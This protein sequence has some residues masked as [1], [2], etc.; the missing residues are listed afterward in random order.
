MSAARI[1][2]CEA[3]PM[4]QRIA[5]TRFDLPQPFGPTTP[6]RPFSIW[7]SVGSTNDL[8]PISRRRVSFMSRRSPSAG[9]AARGLLP[10]SAYGDSSSRTAASRGR[11]N[12]RRRQGNIG[13][14]LLRKFS[15]PLH[16]SNAQTGAP[17]ALRQG[18]KPLSALKIAVDLLADVGRRR[19]ARVLLAVDEKSGRARYAELLG[20]PFAHPFDAVLDLVIRQAGLEALL[21]EAGLLGDRHQGLERLLHHPFPLLL[22]QGVDDR[23]VF[24]VAGAAR[25]H[26]ARH[27][28]RAERELAED[29]VHLS[30]VDVFRFDLGILMDE[31]VRA[32]GAGHRRVFDQGDRRLRVALGLLAER[33]RAHQLLFRSLRERR[34]HEPEAVR[35]TAEN[36]AGERQG[37]RS[38]T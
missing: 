3:S 20:G 30:G 5:S 15:L 36:R 23:E 1:A 32:V 29:E 22:E 6:V 19:V 25:Q 14:A 13:C 26:V 8:K 38:C 12:R 24:V 2:L 31:E 34:T 33:T 10:R 4:T 9:A 18:E 11:M 37:G 7:K 27:I 17:G 35:A 16:R 21:G 28:E